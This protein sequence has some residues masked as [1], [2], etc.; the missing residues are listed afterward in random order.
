V[1]EHLYPLV[2]IC[3]HYIRVVCIEMLVQ[4]VLNVPGTLLIC[5]FVELAEALFSVGL[6]KSFHLHVLLHP[7]QTIQLLVEVIH[8]VLSDSLAVAPAKD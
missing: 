2:W 8:D 3:M 6:L 5:G 1:S 7:A 4:L